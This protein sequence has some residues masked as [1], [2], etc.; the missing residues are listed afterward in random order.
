VASST[1]SVRRDD[2]IQGA[3]A[4]LGHQISDQTVGNILKAHGIEPAPERKR[5]TTWKTFLRS[6][7][8][9]VGAIDFTTL[10]VWTTGSLLRYYHRQA[11]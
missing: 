11:A 5:Q 8:D 10:E 6:H 7:W 3:L 4:N 2:R 1:R 9:V